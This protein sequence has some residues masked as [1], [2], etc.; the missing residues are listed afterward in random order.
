MDTYKA[1]TIYMAEDGKKVQLVN[2]GLFFI[3]YFLIILIIYQ[4]LNRE[5]KNRTW[6][7]YIILLLLILY[8]YIIYPFQSSIYSIFKTLFVKIFEIF[9]YNDN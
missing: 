5:P 8:P 1:K 6:K 9:Y 7:S 4:F 2:T 3:F